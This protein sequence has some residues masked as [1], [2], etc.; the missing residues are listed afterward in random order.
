MKPA[1]ARR[2]QGHHW[3]S[4]NPPNNM[5]I[6]NLNHFFIAMNHRDYKIYKVR[7]TLTAIFFL[8]L[9]AL[10]LYSLMF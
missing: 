2:N 10:F 3:S 7:K 9:T 4:S 5:L 1:K 6:T 8:A